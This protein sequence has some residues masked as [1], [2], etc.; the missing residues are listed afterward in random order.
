[1][2][3]FAWRM[4]NGFVLSTPKIVRFGI[5]KIVSDIDNVEKLKM[6]YESQ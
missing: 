6:L 1:M 3:R 2:Q 5:D 4:H